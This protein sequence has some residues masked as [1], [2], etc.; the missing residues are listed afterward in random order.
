MKS[1]I[2]S[3]IVVISLIL[4]SLMPVLP[5]RADSPIAFPDADG[6]G[7]SNEMETNGWYNLA[8][9]PFYTDPFRADSDRDGLS[10]GEEKL[11]NTNPMDP[12]SPG[13]Y[14]R[15]QNNY[16]TIEYFSA[17]NELEKDD[18]ENWVP[19]YLPML[20]GGDKYLMTDTMVVRRGTALRIGGPISGTLGITSNGLTTLTPAKDIY[21]G[22]W[23]INISTSA[24]VGTYTATLSVGSTFSK[25][26]P[27]YVIFELPTPVTSTDPL[28]NLPQEAIQ[29]F[30]YDDD[31]A[32]KRD[33]VSVWWRAPEWSYYLVPPSTE[34]D[35]APNPPIDCN[36]LYPDSPCSNWQYHHAY[37]YAQAFWTEQFT[38][39]V[40]VRHAMAAIEGQTT[41]AGAEAALAARGDTEM[42]VVLTNIHNSWSTALYKWWTN[43][44]P[45]GPGWTMAGGACQDN[46]NVFTTLLRSAGIPARPFIKDY[47]KTPGHGETGQIGSPYEYDHS[48]LVWV[49]DHWKA[50]SIYLN[51]ELSDPYYPWQH[52]TRPLSELAQYGYTDS[53]ADLILTANGKW[54]WQNG[55]NGGGMVNTVWDGQQEGVP[56]TEFQWPNNNWEYDWNSLRPLEIKRTP[57]MDILNYQAWNGDGWAPSEWY[58]YISGTLIL[59]NTSN[60]PYRGA[61]QTYYL[62]AGV[63]SP[64]NPLENWPY[65]PVPTA[66]SPS[67]PSDVCAQF[68]AG[69]MGLAQS[70]E[71]RQPSL[72]AQNKVPDGAS[73]PVITSSKQPGTSIQI[74]QVTGDHG[75]DLNGDGR[76]E[77]LVVDVTVDSSQEGVF[78]FGG[79][80]QV[81]QAQVRAHED[82]ISLAKGRQ[83]IQ[84]TFDGQD[85]GNWGVDGP[86]HVINM[87]AAGVEQSIPKIVSPSDVL[88]YQTF[89]YPTAA[90]KAGEW[91]V[92]A[93]RLANRYWHEGIDENGD[94]YDESL[95]VHIPISITVPGTFRVEGELHDSQGNLVGSA[96]WTGSEPVATLRFQV[97]KTQP[98]YTLERLM[99]FD[100]QGALLDS[101]FYKVYEITNVGGPIYGGPVALSSIPRTGGYSVMAVTATQ[102]F[103]SQTV[104]TDG[105]GRF[106]KLVFTA[107]VAVTDHGGDY[108]IEGL[109]ED[110]SGNPV[111]WSVSDP[112]PLSV[113]TGQL[114]LS[115]DGRIIHDHMP[116]S[117][118]TQTF[119]LVAVKIFSGTLSPATL[120][121]QVDVAM[122][123]DAYTRDQFDSRSVGLFEDNMERG[124]IT[125]S[126]WTKQTPPWS[127]NTSVWR[128]PSNAWGG[129]GT[130]GWL[131]SAL[132]SLADYVKPALKFNTAFKM[133]NANQKGYLEVSTD[134]TNWTRVATYTNSTQPWTEQYLDLSSYGRAPNLQ[135]RYNITSTGVLT[136]Y[137]DDVYL[138]AFPAVTGASFTYS[139]QPALVGLPVTFTAS[140]TSPS[141][142]SPITYTWNW[143]DSSPVQVTQNAGVL[144]TF[145]N[146]IS[147]TVRLTVENLY[148]SA[149]FTQVV[150][151]VSLPGLSVTQLDS[152]DPVLINNWLT[153]QITVTNL[154]HPATGV[155]L[156]DTLPAAVNLVSITPS[157]GN[158]SGTSEIVCSIGNLPADAKATVRIVVQV[159]PAA[160]R[161][162]TNTVRVA[163]NEFDPFT[164]DNES[165]EYTLVNH[166]APVATN[167]S[168]SVAENAVLTRPAPGVLGNDTDA[169]GD[170]LDAVL[171]NS[172]AHGA[173]TLEAD[174]SF[175][176]TPTASYHGPDSFTYKANDGM[177]DSNIA[178]VNI[179]VNAPPVANNDGYNVNESTVLTDD[180]PG[181]LG[182]DTDA[183]NDPLTAILVYGPGHGALT[184]ET[185]GSFVYTPIGSYHGPDSFTYKANDGL[186]DSNTATVSITVN[187]VPVANNDSYNVNESAVLTVGAPGVLGNDTDAENDPLTAILVY[188]PGHGAL[189]LKPG[190]SF[191][192]TPTVGYRGSDSFI[193]K[194]NDGNASSH[195]ATVS[196]IINHVPIANDDSYDVN[197]NAVLSI[198]AP[199][200]LGNDT[201]SEGHTL[202]AVLDTGPSHGA[203]TL[204]AD[205]SFVY[206]PT[207]GYQG[208]DIFTYKANDGIRDSRVATVS[209]AISWNRVPTITSLSPV[210]VTVGSPGFTLTVN[211][212]NLVNGS[213]VQWN[214]LPRATTFVNSTQVK[215]VILDADVAASGVV[216]ITVVNPAPGGGTS[217]SLSFTIVAPPHFLI[218]LP[219]VTRSASLSDLVERVAI[220]SNGTR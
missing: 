145:A 22:D 5:A 4:A 73:L 75:T 69:G 207:V 204:N 19:K 82:P 167:D 89:D 56:S 64:S 189:T 49:G 10:D 47:N 220:T 151:V 123:T 150:P 203:L 130:T 137:V 67:T 112:Q 152:P 214:G 139:P 85:I 173:L 147:Y 212:A 135:L 142:T 117:P 29:A 216:S 213:I 187:G 196:I 95:D 191:I 94:G 93:A 65:N 99:L 71:T 18:Y 102:T 193:Y 178:T 157:Q 107:G 122:T 134:S 60:P 211:G 86:Y 106:D 217:E 1:S 155:L 209:L 111:A 148:D 160:A 96:T 184:L 176:Y 36:L 164:I 24:K 177:L 58:S 132:V 25:S 7:L 195:A 14:V 108:R 33:E 66:C 41:V 23:V 179:T 57:Y 87:W 136:W 165:V 158:C 149:V 37:G 28:Y 78:Q 140:Y 101:R 188:G 208:L 163:G 172:P 198:G 38:Q 161:T 121:D 88:S 72:A 115:F 27:I 127:L 34:Q 97:S 153:Y 30:D 84:L 171:V 143:D 39:K 199:G 170:T 126:N 116:F 141:T 169:D 16:K 53:Q 174:G 103:A 2:W 40:F 200:V 3:R 83:T 13:I 79:W 168:Y 59:T 197:Q 42:R 192:Y 120:E 61:T 98:P 175:V 46:A 43:D 80:L 181:V 17:L 31:P 68:L 104:D 110:S 133:S 21:N 118:I 81:G 218:Y 156:T 113:G 185:D 180:A 76:F 159:T 186:Q 182:N 194:A 144:H 35:S 125:N 201:D 202:Q 162:I 55:S 44:Y 205:G 131:T 183:E 215:A 70:A 210:S 50:A 45:G 74:L 166:F 62:P 15:Y 100:S 129:V 20:R 32:N 9:G 219:M 6:D 128:S 52:G 11:F 114:T 12:N 154:A 63:P 206:T 48:V 124:A 109:L 138:N 146:S 90:Y 8:G 190:G 54:D 105:D 92:Q 26:M 91:Q 77:E 119:K 51:N